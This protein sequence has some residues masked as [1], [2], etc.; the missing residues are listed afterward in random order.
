MKG[1]RAGNNTGIKQ[2]WETYDTNWWL[3]TAIDMALMLSPSSSV[4]LAW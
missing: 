1:E 2:G 3:V 4:T